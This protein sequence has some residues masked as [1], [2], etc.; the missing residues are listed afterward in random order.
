M[1]S[2]NGVSQTSEEED[3][4]EDGEVQEEDERHPVAELIVASLV[5]EEVHGKEGRRRAAKEGKEEERSLG[6]TPTVM[7]SLVFV[8]AE[9]KESH[10]IDRQEV[11]EDET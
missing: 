3:E 8:E 2:D 9:E 7:S 10:K 1:K 11:I 6:D 4:S 5:A